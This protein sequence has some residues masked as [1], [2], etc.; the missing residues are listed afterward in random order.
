VKMIFHLFMLACIYIPICILMKLKYYFLC[1]NKSESKKNITI[2]ITGAKMYKSTL[3]VK[4][5]GRAGYDIILVETKKFWCSGSRFSKYVNKF[6]TISDAM[7]N[8]DQYVEELVNICLENNAKMFIPVCAP[9]TEKLDSIV[10]DRVATFGVQVLHAPV[11]VFEKLNDKHQFCDLMKAFNLAVP[12]SFLLK[13]N[14]DVFKINEELRQR[15]VKFGESERYKHTFILKNITYDPV[16]RIDLFTLPAK[17]VDINRYLNKIAND[18]NAITNEEP[19]T[20]QRF[21][22]GDMWSSCQVQVDGEICMYT[23]TRSSASCF[24]WYIEE[25]EKIKTWMHNFARRLKINGIFTND[26][27]VDKHDGIPY[28]IECNPRLGSQVSL[29]HGNKNMADIITGNYPQKQIE[30]ISKKSTYTLLNEIFVLLDPTYYADEE[31]GQ[32]KALLERLCNFMNTIMQ[33]CDPIFDEE[34]LL[35]FFMINFFQMPILL[36]DT[37]INNRPWKKI[38]FQIG[39]IVELG[40]Y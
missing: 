10:G 23:V 22:D 35:P 27:I 33:G 40:G 12:E 7:E 14:E 8:P 17:D 36:L 32:N 39:K 1:R 6:C 9:A 30:P 20:A 3:F 13:S 24:N 29:F 18:G 15:I 26:F 37:A 5:M 25:N 38:D 16:H 21:I 11:N 28:A 19:W 4:W 2:V 31:M 34:D